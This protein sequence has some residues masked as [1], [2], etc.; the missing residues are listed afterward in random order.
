MDELISVIVP[1]YNVEKYVE[2]CVLSLIRQSYKNIEIILVDDGSTDESGEICEK[3]ISLDR[4]LNV[5]HKKNGGLSSARNYG[6]KLAKGEILAFIDSDDC[7]HENFFE[8][9]M[10]ARKQTGADIVSSDLFLFS[11]EKDI[12]VENKIASSAK[13]LCGSDILKEYFVPKGKKIYI[14]HGLCMKI[15]NKRL[16]SNL[17]FENG[18]LHEDLFITYKLL[19]R[20]KTFCYVDSPLYFYFQ[21]NTGSICKNFGKKN[22]VDHYDAFEG[23][24]D[25]FETDDV[26]RKDFIHFLI[27]QYL[28]LINKSK[29]IND[30]SLSIYVSNMKKWI[31]KNLRFDSH[32]GFIKK[33]IAYLIVKNIW[34]YNIISKIKSN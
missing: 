29:L 17:W 19:R 20:A 13:V 27:I 3:L 1:V 26:I 12:N 6:M 34:I 9:L 32:I 2:K 31:C 30:K 28:D 25:F 14:Y 18:R 33:I 10:D 4:R 5:Y 24:K 21:G 11:D 8:I 16:F 22:F 7:V 15:Y 23:M